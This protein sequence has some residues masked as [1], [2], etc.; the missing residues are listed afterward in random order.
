MN[1]MKKRGPKMLPCGTPCLMNASEDLFPSR[2]T[3]CFLSERYDG[4]R[5]LG[6]TT[7]T[8]EK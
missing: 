5:I 3:T 1:S 6:L 2:Q 4:L 7:L 8:E